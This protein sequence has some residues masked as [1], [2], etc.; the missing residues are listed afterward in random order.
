MDYLSYLTIPSYPALPFVIMIVILPVET[1]NVTVRD[2]WNTSLFPNDTEMYPEGAIWNVTLIQR[3]V[4][5]GVIMAGTLLGN[6]IIVLVLSKL[7]YRKR[8]SRV[9]IFIL[10]LAIGDLAVCGITMTSELLF[11]VFGE[12]VLGA[13][14]CK[15]IVYAQIVTLA[16]T[17]FILTSMS[18]DRYQ[19][20]CK[21]LQSTVGAIRAKKLIL[22]SW[23]LAFIVA[24]PQLFIF[25]QKENGI[26]TTGR[27]RYECVSQGYTAMWQRKVYFSWLTIY[28]LMIPTVCISYCYV[29]VLRAL[30]AAG[31]EN[32]SNKNDGVYLR[33]SVS[34]AAVIPRA[35]IKTLKLTICIIA[36]FVICWTPY[37][38]VHNIRIFSNY[39]IK[40]PK[41]MIVGAETFA[42][43]N[44]ALNPIFYGYFN[45]RVRK[46]FIE[47]V[48]RKKDF[49]SCVAASQSCS[50]PIDS[51]DTAYSSAVMQNHNGQ[52]RDLTVGINVE[53]CNRRYRQMHCRR[54]R[55][56]KTK[57]DFS[58]T[59]V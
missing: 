15:V 32:H 11:E 28:I 12:W 56:P 46:G 17:T 2:N 41:V 21:P 49:R 13:I 20:I 38:I 10:N 52:R 36:S 23:I 16:S 5:L 58:S 40:V 57:K 50:N 53:M 8:S 43:L 33:R 54:N 42:L 7:R 44:S 48:Y 37:F 1:F 51:G 6:T 31:R 39:N 14:A 25:V 59:R 22:A 4:T 26:T 9:N 27:I 30:C 45:V 55:R 34:A 24:V 29:N 19:A 3:V 35:K 47:I 18:Y